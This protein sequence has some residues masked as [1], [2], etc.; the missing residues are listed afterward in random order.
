LTHISNK[1]NVT[2]LIRYGNASI[3]AY[4][5]GGSVAEESISSIRN[6][7]AFNTQDKV[8]PTGVDVPLHPLNSRSS[9]GNMT[10]T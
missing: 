1:A 3:E 8:S 2:Q 10:F 6:A 9:L 5:V 7:V 4:A